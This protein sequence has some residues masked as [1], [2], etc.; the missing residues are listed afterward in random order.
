MARGTG[1]SAGIGLGTAA[2]L[3]EEKIV[4]D[5]TGSDADGR[6]RKSD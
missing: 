4:I 2:I 5:N 1:A 3:R 6:N